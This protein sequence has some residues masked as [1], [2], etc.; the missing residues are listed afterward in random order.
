MSQQISIGIKSIKRGPIPDDGTMG[1]VLSI[2]GDTYKDSASFKENKATVFNVQVE[3]TDDPIYQFF[4]KSPKILAFALV[5]FTPATI[6][7][8][9]GGT[10]VAGVWQEPDNAV[11]IEEAYQVISQ[12]DLLIEIPRGSVSAYFNAD[13]KK[14]AAALINMEVTPLKPNGAGVPAINISKYMPPVVNAGADQPALAAASG[15]VTGT[16]TAYRGAIVSKLWTVDTQ[17]V[18]ATTVLAT[19]TA[20]TTAVTGLA[21]GITKLRLTVTDENDYSNSALVT[22]TRTS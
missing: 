18:G 19:P 21:L 6:K 20:L 15:S 1:T 11:K 8:V 4:T 13:L 7:L 2:L 12:T 9:K 3:E 5:D 22:L 16:A 14:G 10:V 17:P